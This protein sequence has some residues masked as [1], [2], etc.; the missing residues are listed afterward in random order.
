MSIRHNPRAVMWFVGAYGPAV[1]IFVLGIA[2]LI[3]TGWDGWE[4]TF[5]Y[6]MA[7]LNMWL[8]ARQLRTSYRSGYWTGRI[9]LQM[10]QVGLKAP[11][12]VTDDEVE[13]WDQRTSIAE[14][15]ALR[16]AVQRMQR[17]YGSE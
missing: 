10:E 14:A 6:T 11:R 16:D 15:A 9:D 13:P 3:A 8:I 2:M 12:Q 5:A 4:V 17:E 1:A 7:A